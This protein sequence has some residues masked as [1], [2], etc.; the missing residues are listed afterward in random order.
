LFDV[1]LAT[2]PNLTMRESLQLLSEDIPDPRQQV[3]N[4]CKQEQDFEDRPILRSLSCIAKKN[5][6]YLVANVQDI[7][8]CPVTNC[9]SDGVLMYSTQIAFDREGNLIARYHKYH[10]WGEYHSNVPEEQELVF[11]DTDFGAR[12]GMYVCFDPVF[13]EPIIPL[14]EQ[15]NVKTM[16]LSIHFCD[17]HP[18]LVSPRIDQYWSIG[19][20]KS[21]LINILTS[22]K[23]TPDWNGGI[24]GGVQKEHNMWHGELW[25]ICSAKSTK[26]AVICNMSSIS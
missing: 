15:F 22:N 7:K 3:V 25:R 10:L 2:D 4:P 14:I 19:L 13:K 5:K 9:T 16:A 11:F 6:V 1:V 26:V 24:S 20:G 21:I 17:E 12:I 18:F 23:A 8:Q